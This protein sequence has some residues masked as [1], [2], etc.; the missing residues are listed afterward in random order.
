MG[1]IIN[2]A[3]VGLGRVGSTFLKKLVECERK[4]ISIVAVAEKDD[5]SE[6]L[7]LARE[8][9]INI[10]GD[11]Q[12]IALGNKVDIIFDLT[13]NNEARRSLRMAMVK[14]SNAH[15]V[16]A[17]EIV[18]FFTWNLIGE[19]GGLPDAHEVKGY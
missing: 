10:L 11:E 16:I 9:G 1:K 3:I 19:E 7:R 12:I 17:S 5:N 8:N 15:T 18:A 14:S 2:V 6:G 13:G 4:G